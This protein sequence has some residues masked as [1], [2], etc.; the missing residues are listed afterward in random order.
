MFCLFQAEVLFPDWLMVR[1]SYGM[2]GL[3]MP[4]K[5]ASE[6][7]SYLLQHQQRRPPDHLVVE[8][9]DMH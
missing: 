1:L 8:W 7:S 2:N 4:N 5:D 9:F 6:L 3:L